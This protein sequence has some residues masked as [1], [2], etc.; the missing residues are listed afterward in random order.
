MAASSSPFAATGSPSSAPAPS[1]AALTPAAGPSA[2]RARLPAALWLCSARGCSGSRSLSQSCLQPVAEESAGLECVQQ[3]CPPPPL[4]HC[5]G[6]CH[7]QA[8]QLHSAP[9]Q[10]GT[11]PACLCAP[12]LQPRLSQHSPMF[13][14][15]SCTP[16]P[17]HGHPSSHAVGFSSASPGL[18]CQ[19]PARSRA[20]PTAWA[21]ARFLPGQRT[22]C[23]GQ[24]Q[25]PHSPICPGGPLHSRDRW[26]GP[27]EEQ[28]CPHPL[29]CPCPHPPPH[30]CPCPFPLPCPLP[31]P[32]CRVWM[33]VN[34]ASAPELL[35]QAASALVGAGGLLP[36]RE[37]HLPA[38]PWPCS[39]RE[40]SGSRSLSQSCLQPGARTW[41]PFSFPCCGFSS[42]M[43]GHGPKH[44]MLCCKQPLP[45]SSGLE[46]FATRITITY[47]DL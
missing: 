12:S 17:G 40:W 1:T 44:E 32:Q 6:Q 46:T 31:C 42:D 5:S 35:G 20:L 19:L 33:N 25:A 39:A 37:P 28:P 16:G 7:N 24:C 38:A 36:L 45:H 10:R 15:P 13:P 3:H 2:W 23:L 27:R 18:R 41:T 21:P 47:N 34:P 43:E 30:P 22:V 8:S 26:P 29:P 14:A 4:P 9:L 11:W